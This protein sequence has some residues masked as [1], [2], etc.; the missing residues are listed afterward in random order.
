MNRFELDPW[1][2]REE[3]IPCG[4]ERQRVDLGMAIRSLVL[5]ATSQA[6]FLLLPT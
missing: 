5:A 6:S 2:S 4:G 1:H 3:R